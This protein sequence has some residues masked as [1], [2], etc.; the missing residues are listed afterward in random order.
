MPRQKKKND[1]QLDKIMHTNELI[2]SS[3]FYQSNQPFQSN[4]QFKQR[5]TREKVNLKGG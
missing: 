5:T 1:L 2:V 4:A 3:S